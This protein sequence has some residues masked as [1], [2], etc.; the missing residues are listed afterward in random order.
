MRQLQ[1]LQRQ[2]HLPMLTG[3]ARRTLIKDTIKKHK[4]VKIDTAQFRES[5]SRT[6][7]IHSTDLY[8]MEIWKKKAIVEIRRHICSSAQHGK[9]LWSDETKIELCVGQK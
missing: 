4:K 7:L 8:F 9:S 1:T 3:R 6:I 2:N 5:V